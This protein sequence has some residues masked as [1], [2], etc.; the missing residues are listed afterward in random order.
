MQIGDEYLPDLVALEVSDEVPADILGQLRWLMPLLADS[1]RLAP[2]RSSSRN[3]CTPRR[4]PILSHPRYG[5][6]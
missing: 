6:C 1:S 5:F 3:P 4:T 2:R